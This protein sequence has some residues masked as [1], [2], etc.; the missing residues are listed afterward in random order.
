MKKIGFIIILS[1]NLLANSN[2]SFF[3]AGIIHQNINN[4]SNT[5]ALNICYSY[6]NYDKFGFDIGYAQSFFKAE[7]RKS[8]NENSFSALYIFPTYL[9][10]LN[11]H[12]AFKAKAGYAKNESSDDGLAY[13]VDIIFQINQKSGFSV[14]FQKMSKDVNYF[15]VNT[16]YKF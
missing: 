6:I 16:I 12:T 1:I 2:Q 5:Q 4:Y 9:I 15:M 7:N 10:P 11:N 14:G 13:G 8:K 3:S